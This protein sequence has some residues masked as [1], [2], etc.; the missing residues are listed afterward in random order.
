MM[1]SNTGLRLA[2]GHP[3]TREA[4]GSKANGLGARFWIIFI[5]L[6]IVGFQVSLESTIVVTAMPSIVRELNIGDNYV[7]VINASF[8]TM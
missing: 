3:A 7:W 6:W 1:G 4:A 2:A 5:G 8:L